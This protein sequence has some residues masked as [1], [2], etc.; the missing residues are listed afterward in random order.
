MGCRADNNE[1]PFLR[2]SSKSRLTFLISV[3]LLAFIKGYFKTIW[4]I[5][6]EQMFLALFVI[7]LLSKIVHYLKLTIVFEYF[8]RLVCSLLFG[9]FRDALFCRYSYTDTNMPM[10]KEK[11]IKSGIHAFTAEQLEVIPEQCIFDEVLKE[12]AKKPNKKNKNL[13]SH[14]K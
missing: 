10:G 7:Q 5:T 3:I 13:K 4:P 1:S 14:K 2:V 8:Y 11:S 9:G 6:F 12:S